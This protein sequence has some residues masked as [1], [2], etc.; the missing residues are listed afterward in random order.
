MALDTLTLSIPPAWPQVA[1]Y[2]GHR[3]TRAWVRSVV[4]DALESSPLRFVPILPL[5]W[6]RGTFKA[7]RT[8]D[9]AAYEPHDV[10]GLISGPFG[11]YAGGSFIRSDPRRETG[12]TL[13]HVPTGRRLASLDRVRSCRRLAEELA[14]L[15]MNWHRDDPEKVGGADVPRVNAL[16]AQYERAARPPEPSGVCA[17][18]GGRRRQ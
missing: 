6:H 5:D 4:A 14:P 17:G 16:V 18:V 13:A 11:L 2:L 15:R 8:P 10:R 12:F 1:R 9:G 3:D 7:I